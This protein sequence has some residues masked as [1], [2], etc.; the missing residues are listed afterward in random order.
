MFDGAG[1]VGTLPR[2]DASGL[3]RDGAWDVDGSRGAGIVGVAA[4]D[5]RGVGAAGGR[6]VGAAGVGGAGRAD[7]RRDGLLRRLLPGHR[8]AHGD[9][10]YRLPSPATRRGPPAVHP[11]GGAVRT[12]PGG[13]PVEPVARARILVGEPDLPGSRSSSRFCAWSGSGRARLWEG[14]SLGG[15]ERGPYRVLNAGMILLLRSPR[16]TGSRAAGSCPS[17]SPGAEAEGRFTVPVSYPCHEVPSSASRAGDGASSGR[18]SPGRRA[19]KVAC[20]G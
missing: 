12:R 18:T 6:R 15:L 10:L 8:G 4:G 14:P 9:S 5:A 13:G 16:C 7:S 20:A 19:G 2:R 11:R 1:F 17:P 3:G